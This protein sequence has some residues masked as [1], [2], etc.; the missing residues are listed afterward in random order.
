MVASPSR[1]AIHA[2]ERKRGEIDGANL[3]SGTRFR[4]TLVDLPKPRPRQTREEIGKRAMK[5][6]KERDKRQRDAEIPA[7]AYQHTVGWVGRILN[8][9]A[10]PNRDGLGPGTT[11]EMR[12]EKWATKKKV[13]E[14]P[15]AQFFAQLE[16]GPL[17]GSW[18]WPEDDRTRTA[19]TKAITKYESVLLE[20]TGLY[21]PLHDHSL[22][23]DMPLMDWVDEHCPSVWTL[24]KNMPHSQWVSWVTQFQRL[25]A[26]AVHRQ[27]IDRDA[28]NLRKVVVC[29]GFP[30]EAFLI[31]FII[32]DDAPHTAAHGFTTRP[33]VYGPHDVVNCS[34]SCPPDRC[35]TK[36]AIHAGCQRGKGYTIKRVFYAQELVSFMTCNGKSV[37]SIWPRK[38]YWVNSTDT[39]WLKVRDPVEFKYSTHYGKLT[40]LFSYAQMDTDGNEMP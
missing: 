10:G 28:D 11:G 18:E 12:F 33:H 29:E 26:A 35:D 22:P 13:F 27:F 1:L 32:M 7:C 8:F 34:L 31:L 16:D 19:I 9:D 21:P 14:T 4:S 40:V 36:T 23:G 38:K 20:N 15:L 39:A 5:K 17:A 2:E 25:F 6:R 37:S 24:G 3:S 30:I